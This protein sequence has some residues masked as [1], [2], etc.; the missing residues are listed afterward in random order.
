MLKIGLCISETIGLTWKD[1]DMNK[2]E[3]CINHQIQYRK[4]KGE[5]KLYAKKQ[6]QVPETE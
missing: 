6:K 5:M 1:V 2:R 4:I 3:I